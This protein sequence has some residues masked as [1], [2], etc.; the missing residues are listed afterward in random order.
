MQR[1]GCTGLTV[2]LFDI[3]SRDCSLDA[4][5][6][7]RLGSFRRVAYSR[8]FYRKSTHSWVSTVAAPLITKMSGIIRGRLYGRHCPGQSYD[9]Q[10]SF[11][12]LVKFRPER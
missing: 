3:G 4:M 7:Q 2:G 11:T 9:G 12:I 6:T 1:T 8:F 5:S 10:R